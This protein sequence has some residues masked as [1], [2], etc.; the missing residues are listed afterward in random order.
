MLKV[1]PYTCSLNPV[2]HARST[3]KKMQV[4]SYHDPPK[5]DVQAYYKA[6][7]ECYM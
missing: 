5:V 2:Q 6:G 7:S 3:A 4:M 1:D